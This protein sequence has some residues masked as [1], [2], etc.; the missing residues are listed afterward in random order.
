MNFTPYHADDMVYTDYLPAKTDSNSPQK[1]AWPDDEAFD[2]RERD[3]MLQFINAFARLNQWEGDQLSAYRLLERV[4]REKLPADV[5]SQ[6]N[7]LA[8]L[9][10]THRRAFKMVR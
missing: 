5:L 10:D 9:R 8:W 7:A 4:L 2:I 1:S 3:Q 6:K